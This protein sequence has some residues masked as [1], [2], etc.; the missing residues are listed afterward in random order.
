MRE[1]NWNSIEDKIVRPG[2]EAKLTPLLLYK[3]SQSL[4]RVHRL[5]NFAITCME[6][7]VENYSQ[8]VK[9]SHNPDFAHLCGPRRPLD[10]GVF[11]SMFGKLLDHPKVTSNIRG[12]TD[13]IRSIDGMKFKLSRISEVVSYQGI[14]HLSRLSPYRKTQ[15]RTALPD[16]PITRDG[17]TL[18]VKDGVLEVSLWDLIHNPVWRDSGL[19][20]PLRKGRTAK[21]KA[22]KAEVRQQLFYPFI[23]H[24]PTRKR[25][26]EDLVL[27]INDAV[28]ASWPEWLRADVCQDLVVAVLSGELK[29]DEL[30][31]ENVKEFSRAVFKMHPIKYGPLS[32]DAVI[33][34]DD[35]RTVADVM[36]LRMG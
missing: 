36:K 19:F 21:P 22:P 10:H 6:H 14:G 9:L 27:A 13:Y 11:P 15:I 3:G 32:L 18:Y 24:N 16:G 35:G 25:E 29:Q 12:L 5:W 2:I 17:E 20:K 26:G 7:E 30:H 31:A 1:A 8:A 34:A 33:A 23:M 4:G 28:P